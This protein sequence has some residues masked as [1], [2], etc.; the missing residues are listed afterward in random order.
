MTKKL[1][2]MMEDKVIGPAK[3]YARKEGKSSPG[4]VENYLKSITSQGSGTIISPKVSGL[5]SVIR[6]PENFD[7]KK[8][9]G[10]ALSERNQA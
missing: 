1:T 6:L 8:E 4:I 3:E 7:H 5:R 9:L 2:L 10:K